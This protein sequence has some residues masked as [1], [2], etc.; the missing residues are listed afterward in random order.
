[1]AAASCQKFFLAELQRFGIE[2]RLTRV[3]KKTFSSKKFR[4]AK[5]GVQL[6]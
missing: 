2:K 6:A 1:M 3:N 4:S 5:P